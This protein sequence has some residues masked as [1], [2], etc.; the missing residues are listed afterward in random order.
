[1]R[2]KINTCNCA[3]G[4]KA[5]NKYV[6]RFVSDLDGFATFLNYK[7]SESNRLL[8]AARVMI[9]AINTNGQG[10]SFCAQKEKVGCGE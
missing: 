6:G 4:G 2:M 8:L 10:L 9:R 1:M 5:D 7:F 3:G